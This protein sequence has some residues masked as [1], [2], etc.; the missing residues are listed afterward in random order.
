MIEEKY[1]KLDEISHVLLRPG[2]YIGS[3]TA[4][5]DETYVPVDGH[6]VKC[7]TTWIPALLKIFDEIISNSVD[8][9]K[10]PEG[11][12]LDTI[13]V[14]IDQVTGKITV[15]DNGGIIVAKH[16][17]HDQYIPEMIF[18]LR[19]GSNFDD[20]QDTEL[21]GQNGEGAS[22]TAIFSKEF[23][24][25]TA[26]GKNEFFQIH[27]DNTR[28]KTVPVIKK[29]RKQFTTITFE[30]EYERFNL[31]GLD[32]DNYLKLC[33]RVYD[34]AG[35]NPKLK[36]FLNDKQIV[37]KSFED[38][39]RMYTNE[40]VYDQNDKWQIGVGKGDGFNHISF[41]NNNH[42]LIGGRH[43]DYIAYQVI[44]KLR[45]HIEKKHRVQ[46]KPSEIKNHISLYIN[47]N[48][49]KPRYSSQTKEEMITEVK[50]FGTT[51]DVT[52]KFTALIIKSGV[53]Q[54]V[55]DWVQMKENA[56]L[57]AELR[58]LNK[59]TEK[60]DP[61]RV[62]KF[63]DANEKKD[64]KKCMVFLTEGDSAGKAILNSRNDQYHALYPLKGKPVN[65]LNAKPKKLMENDT[66]K[67]LLTITGLKLG[68]KVTSVDQLRFGKIVF[69]TDAD[70]DGIHIS[71]LLI[72]MFHTFWPELFEL[73]IIGRFKT[74]VVKAWI[75]KEVRCFYSEQDFKAWAAKTTKPYKSKYYKG[76]GTSTSAEFKEYLERIDE[77][78]ITF[79]IETEDDKESIKLAFSSE[80]GK[81]NNRKDW[82][83]LLD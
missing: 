65:V 27:R 46:V 72:N 31:D 81:T 48:I 77:N 25:H 38:Y 73:G 49:V 12:H 68:E 11:A 13:K 56:I 62:E 70:N 67:N 1:Q 79:R 66:F 75:G 6:F 5:T 19:S 20:T 30:P 23:T 33:K 4:H 37:I 47:C 22:L 16:P 63:D 2:R 24:V 69:L 58:K 17:V 74:P 14:T 82:L 55:L 54:S 52:D 32:D 15:H 3:I 60:V 61:I 76:L 7:E 64:R 80:K 28:D 35:C 9:S 43:V 57:Q 53:V 40:F 39:I 45:E 71:G 18:E 21:N 51:F 44:N 78:L 8:F 26:D 36:V 10:T 42:T 83:A 29:S 59:N 50:N 41:V 34:V